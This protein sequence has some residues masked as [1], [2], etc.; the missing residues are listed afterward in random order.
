MAFKPTLERIG[1]TNVVQIQYQAPLN[2][3]IPDPHMKKLG[4]LH[5]QV[6]FQLL[7]PFSIATISA[8]LG[9]TTKEVDE[10]LNN[11]RRDMLNTDLHCWT[12][13]LAEPKNHPNMVITADTL[14]LPA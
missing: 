13:M 10:L 2:S 9:Y 12:P 5:Q 4:E 3:W 7:R 6:I 8:G 14:D 11:V 1:F